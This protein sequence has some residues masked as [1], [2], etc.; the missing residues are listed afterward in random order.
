VVQAIVASMLLRP[1]GG[2]RAHFFANHVVE[3][4]STRIAPLICY[5][6][7]IVWPVL[8]SLLGDPNI[9][10]AVGNGWWMAGISIVAI[11]RMSADAWANPRRSGG[12]HAGVEPGVP[13]Y[14]LHRHLLD[15]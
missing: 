6:Q 10:V 5:E 11:Q 7:L 12:R 1:R 9:I 14:C 3:I 13:R 15:S 4:G 2:A 8:Q